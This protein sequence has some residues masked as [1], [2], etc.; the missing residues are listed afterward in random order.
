V[1]DRETAAL[2]A[3]IRSDEERMLQRILREIPKLT[4]AVVGAELHDD[5]SYELTETG[6]ADAVRDVGKA[7]GKVARKAGTTAKR[8]ARQARKVPGVAEAE[9]RVK[10]AVASADDLAIARYDDLT[11]D[12]ITSRLPELSQIDLAKID[13]YERRN[14]KRTTI[15]SRITSLRGSEPWPGYDE[16][17]AVEIRTAL[18]EADDALTKDVRAYERGHKNRAGVVSSTE[19]ELSGKS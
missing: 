4:D 19:R 15:L 14:E 6:A 8:T 1:G 12:E 11:A 13:S 16:L 7:S 10:G 17:T 2:A 9:G 18:A 3:S 5:P